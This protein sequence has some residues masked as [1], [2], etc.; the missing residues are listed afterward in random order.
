MKGRLTLDKVNAAINDMATCA[1]A[2][3][4]LIAAPWKKLN[5]STLVRAL[6]SKS[7]AQKTGGKKSVKTFL[8]TDV[9]RPTLKFDTTGKGILTL[10]LRHLGRITEDR[11]G[12]HRVIILLR[13][14]WIST[15]DH[16]NYQFTI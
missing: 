14:Q 1:D 4:Q 3:A 13:P 5:E 16:I 10:I 9:K 11:I 7:F 15:I 2:N 8:E 12:H 6:V